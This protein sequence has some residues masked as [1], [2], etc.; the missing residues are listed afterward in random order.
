[1]YKF[2]PNDLQ[3]CPFVALVCVD[4]PP[5]SPERTPNNIKNNLQSMIK[6]AIENDNAVTS[7]Q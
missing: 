6:E 1:M 4:H 5:P 7:G 3:E 2:I